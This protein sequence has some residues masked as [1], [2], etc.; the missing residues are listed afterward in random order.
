MNRL[1]HAHTTLL[2]CE[3]Q[4]GLEMVLR[5]TARILCASPQPPCGVCAV[6]RRVL[7]GTHPDVH[8]LD[9]GTSPIRIDDVRA[10]L[11]EESLRA[12]EA[13]MKTYV[14]VHAQNMNAVCQNAL[15]KTLE[16]PDGDTRFYLIAEDTQSLLPT[17]LSRCAIQRVDADAVTELARRLQQDGATAFCA[18]M[19][20]MLSGGSLR[21]ARTI[22]GDTSFFEAG[23]RAADA[24]CASLA[25]EHATIAPLYSFV[26][27]KEDALDAFV[28]WRA[29]L[30]DMLCSSAHARV[31]HYLLNPP[32]GFECCVERLGARGATALLAALDKAQMQIEGNVSA[33]LAADGFFAAAMK[34]KE[35]YGQGCR[36]SF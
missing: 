26:T 12:Y 31:P 1:S 34:E 36:R 16:E 21:H 2:V 22:A 3:A 14:I 27:Q 7:S 6:C 8:V 23:K 29:V 32:H 5:E 13:P 19:A 10:F 9:R 28:W 18:Q 33:Q 25:D 17:I 4:T 24:L 30:R 15:L 11:A 35:K 20:A